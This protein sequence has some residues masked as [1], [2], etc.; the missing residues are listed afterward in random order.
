MTGRPPAEYGPSNTEKDHW[1]VGIIEGFFLTGALISTCWLMVVSALALAIIAV[2]PDID[3]P[4]R[5]LLPFAAQTIWLI[6]LASI[7]G[8]AVIGMTGASILVRRWPLLASA[9]SIGAGI[10][11]ASVSRIWASVP[12]SDGVDWEWWSGMYLEM[13]GAFLTTGIVAALV[14]LRLHRT[15]R[16]VSNRLGFDLLRDFRRWFE[17]RGL[18]ADS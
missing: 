1:V 10:G 4:V 14:H 15:L 6:S 2:L 5:Q 13:S 11:F 17:D 7:L 3:L 12:P 9:A 8:L 18:P 16:P